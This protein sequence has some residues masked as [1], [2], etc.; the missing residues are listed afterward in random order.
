MSAPEPVSR[1]SAADYLEAEKHADVKHEYLR[2]ETW[3]IVGATDA[4]VTV[5]L[6]LAAALK[7]HLRGG[8][9]RV[10]ISDMKLRIETANAFFYPDVMVTC[11][12]RDRESEYYKQ[13]PCLVV[14]VLSPSTEAFD[15]GNKFAV[16]RE[17]ASLQE[18]ALIDCRRRAVDCFRRGLEGQW[19]LY[20]YGEGD[21]VTFAA[22]QLSLP[23]ALL[24]EDVAE[25]GGSGSAAITES[26]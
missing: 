3:A 10:Y 12:A 24:Y 25:G 26:G 7:N 9:C 21:E 14:E 20:P 1:I 18:Y 23:I 17:L 6:N 13:Y 15:R 19:V 5:A 16:Y 2:G 8:S 22:V 4:H 11:G